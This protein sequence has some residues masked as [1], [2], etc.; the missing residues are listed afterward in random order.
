MTE[1]S[2]PS[3]QGRHHDHVA[4]LFFFFPLDGEELHRARTGQGVESLEQSQDPIVP[5]FY[6]IPVIDH[7]DVFPPVGTTRLSQQFGRD[8]VRYRAWRR[9]GGRRR[10]G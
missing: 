3:G 2:L 5:N 7:F 6:R 9:R 1:T 4:L 8:E 10:W